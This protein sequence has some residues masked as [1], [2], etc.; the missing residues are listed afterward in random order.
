MFLHPWHGIQPGEQAPELVDCIIEI[1]RGS[2]QKYELDKESGL[3]RLDRVLYSAVFYPANYGFIPRTYCDDRDPLDILVLGQHEVVPLC[4]LTARPIGVMQMVDQDEEDD[5]II[6]V[7][8]HDPAFSHYRDIS[9]LPQH[10]LYELQQ[11]FEDYKKLEHKKVRIERRWAGNRPIASLKKA[12]S[13]MTPRSIRP[14]ES[15]PDAPIL[16]SEM[17]RED[18]H[19]RAP[20]RRTLADAAR[21]NA[22]RYQAIDQEASLF[23]AYGQPA[24]DA[25]GVL[26]PNSHAS[27]ANNHKQSL[28][29]APVNDTVASVGAE[30]STD[31]ESSTNG[32]LLAENVSPS[33]VA[34]LIEGNSGDCPPQSSDS[35]S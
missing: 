29:G 17:K 3:L 15:V 25:N 21:R 31:S 20:S 4:I 24:V 22:A 11:F 33:G 27:I 19:N 10:T 5:K 7:H 1:P 23:A 9:E 14:V 12:C 13:C 34:D 28:D 30:T 2:H 26:P 6:A 35:A 8:E 32:A 16:E 18:A